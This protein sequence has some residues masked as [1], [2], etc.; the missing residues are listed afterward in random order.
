M[1][2][3]EQ[4][5]P[6]HPGSLVLKRTGTGLVIVDM[7]EKFAPVIGDFD[8]VVE[9]IMRLLLTFQ[10]FEMPVLLTEQYPKGLGST[11]GILRKQFGCVDIIEK[12]DFSCARVPL[13]MQQLRDKEVTTVVLCGVETH[14]CITQTALDLVE[15]GLQV[16][17]VAD[18][19]GSRHKLDYEIA[20]RKMELGGV[21][22]ATTEMCLFELVERAGSD[23][24]RNVSRLVKAHLKIP[25]TG[26]VTPSSYRNTPLPLVDAPLPVTGQDLRE[27]PAPPKPVQKPQ[28]PVPD[29]IEE[30]PQ[31]IT[32]APASAIPESHGE[33]GPADIPPPAAPVQEL[34]AEQEAVEELESN[35]E[36]LLTEAEEELKIADD[37]IASL[38]EN[39]DDNNTNQT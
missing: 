34:S 37:D 36:L 20:L 33:T 23:S 1:N 30:P 15:Q 17:V 24:F 27:K 29:R 7:Q 31:V 6:V 9:N 22:P 5:Q 8:A 21:I 39:E 16:F 10:M 2:H 18:A 26:A 25:S 28:P 19:V 32:V 13:F 38:L 35:E 4:R 11:V 14:V 12:L 3:S